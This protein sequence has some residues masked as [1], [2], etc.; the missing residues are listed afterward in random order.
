MID[1]LQKGNGLTDLVLIHGWGFDGRVWNE[2][3]PYVKDQWRVT[4]IDLPGYDGAVKTSCADLDDIVNLVSPNVPEGATILAW[5]LGGLIATK[6]IGVRKDIKALVSIAS[7]PCFLNKPDWQ[8][9]VDPV[10]L[11][12]LDKLLNKDKAKALQEFAGLVSMGDGSPRRTMNKLN[13]YIGEK[14]AGLGAL[15]AGLAILKE[16][17]LRCQLAE[18]QGTISMIFGENDILVKRSAGKAVQELKPNIRTI[19]ISGTGHAPFISR[20]KETADALMDLTGN[21]L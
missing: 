4:T 10:D 6:L 11:I 21:N 13:D 8:H 16:E 12:Q 15:K 2:F 14:T 17:D 19:E 18:E 20:P 3:V 9:G 7:S 1:V 5:S